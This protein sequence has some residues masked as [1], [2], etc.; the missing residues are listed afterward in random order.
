MVGFDISD[1]E[2]SGADVTLIIIYV[3]DESLL[4]YSA[5]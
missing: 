3:E 1:S 2:T 4:E 5:V